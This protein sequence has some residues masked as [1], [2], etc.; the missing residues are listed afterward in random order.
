MSSFSNNRFSVST[1][2]YV[3][4]RWSFIFSWLRKKI[5][6]EDCENN[7][8]RFNIIFSLSLFKTY[9]CYVSDQYDGMILWKKSIFKNIFKRLAL[10]LSGKA[11]I[12]DAICTICMGQIHCCIVRIEINESKF[13]ILITYQSAIMIQNHRYLYDIF[14]SSLP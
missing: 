7:E 8:C 2:S 12:Y 14:F 11:N 3:R 13:L 10:G 6:W 4:V 9:A 5:V 1:V